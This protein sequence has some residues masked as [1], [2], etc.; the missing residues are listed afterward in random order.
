MKILYAPD[1][2]ILEAKKE[3]NLMKTIVILLISCALFL[4]TLVVSYHDKLV[5]L[6]DMKF[7]VGIYAFLVPFLGSLF[8]GFL[9][10][11]VVNTLG[12]NGDY[13]DGLTTI[14]YSLLPLSI[15][16]FLSMSLSVLP[17]IINVSTTDQNINLLH[18]MAI[19]AIYMFF[20]AE[21]LAIIFRSVKELFNADMLTA[22][23]AVLIIGL[24]V[25]I[26]LF[27]LMF[28]L[29]L[30]VILVLFSVFSGLL[31]GGLPGMGSGSLLV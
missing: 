30:S 11:V 16:V 3:R 10:I 19:Y 1:E 17:S 25:I 23:I 5:D 4:A 15:G 13:F 12:G 20:S 7:P 6:F 2:A 18:S 8:L 22:F 26:P 29:G 14:T 31:G 21:S 27:I 28:I 9:L 24:V